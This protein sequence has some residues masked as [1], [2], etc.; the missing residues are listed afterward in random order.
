MEGFVKKIISI[1]ITVAIVFVA[2]SCK[3]EEA[4]TKAANS[5]IINFVVGEVSVVA[6]GQQ[7]AAQ[8]GD[9]ITQGMVVKT[10]KNS[11]VDIYFSGSV[12]RILENSSVVMKEL[13]KELQT[14]KELSEF[15]VEKGK[16][17]S[18]VSRKLTEGEKFKVSTPT[19]VAGVRGT[20]FLV[21]ENEGKSK[22]ACIEG[23]VAVHEA[24]KT[25]SD[26]VIVE[27]GKEASLEKGKPISVSELKAQNLENIRRIKDEIKEIR[28][29]IRRKF[30][31]QREEIRK[32]VIEQKDINKQRVEDQ[33][34]MDKANVEALKE[35][36]KI[37]AE[38]IKG[39]IEGKKNEAKE[40][41]TQVNKPDVDTAKPDVNSAKPT[42][43][44]FDVKKPE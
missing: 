33:K 35:S 6:D 44:K 38:Q 11:V 21:E 29:E 9:P 37:Q 1:I 17:F 24:D 10:G 40:A 22:I 15:Y 30:E 4:P 5:G 16:L 3:K 34:A 14:N 23:A 28:E 41:V 31:E 7:K 36:T 43:K 25:E 42:I 39:D 12:I 26:A 32:A 8:A 2:A 20:E 27:A 13:I 18:K 19:A